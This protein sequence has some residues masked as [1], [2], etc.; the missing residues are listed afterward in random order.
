MDLPKS[1]SMG[2][3]E[4]REV[5]FYG[6]IGALR[7]RAERSR[8]REIRGKERERERERETETETERERD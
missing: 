4:H 6:I 7:E 2:S 8:G 3:L 1:F 5:I